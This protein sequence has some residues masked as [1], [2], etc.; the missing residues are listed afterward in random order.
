MPAVSR[1]IG[2][3]EAVSRAERPVSLAELTNSLGYP[4]SSLLGICLTLVNGGLLERTEHGR[5]ALGT[6][7]VGLAH[8][9]LASSKITSRFLETWDA[10]GAMPE[11]TV[12]LSVLD[13]ADVVYVACRNGTQGLSLNYRIGMRLPA[14]CTAS[15]KAILSTLAPAAL[16]RLFL[17]RSLE[18]LT[19]SSITTF[20]ALQADLEV[21][22]ER[23][24]AISEEAVRGGISCVGAPIF[25]QAGSSAT[26]AVA[27]GLL[28]A[29]LRLPEKQAQV[30]QTVTQFASD[31]TRRL[32]GG[33]R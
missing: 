23:G 30:I 6:R 9:Y 10:L 7:V 3:L 13:G 22:R 2:I 31:L 26:G 8:S 19:P 15:G 27:L 17:G 1:A 20:A 33:A 21:V 25:E 16:E 29:E 28:S 32:G 11:E 5:Y 14:T 24:Y 12:V 4:K 18:Q